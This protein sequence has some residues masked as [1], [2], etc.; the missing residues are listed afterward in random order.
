MDLLKTL[1][2]LFLLLNTAYTTGKLPEN[3]CNYY[4][5]THT[6]EKCMQTEKITRKICKKQTKPC[7]NKTRLKYNLITKT[8]KLNKAELATTI[9]QDIYQQK[10][11]Y[12]KPDQTKTIIKNAGI[13][14]IE[15]SPKTKTGTIYIETRHNIKLPKTHRKCGK[16][17]S[18]QK[19]KK[20]TT[21]KVN[22]KL[23]GRGKTIKYTVE[24]TKRLE[25]K[26]TLQINVKYQ[27]NTFKANKTVNKSEVECILNK[28]LEKKT[29]IT[30]TD[31]E[32]IKIRRFGSAKL[33]ETKYGALKL[34][35]RNSSKELKRN[36]KQRRKLK[37]GEAFKIPSYL[38]IFASIYYLLRKITS[39]T[40]SKSF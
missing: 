25:I 31:S 4:E 34:E 9:N 33:K 3:Q 36:Y 16:T 17:Y 20:K 23:E 19:L 38:V 30:L 32:T 2:I 10:N 28:S 35:K 22:N 6:R 15:T 5:N 21:T 1:P 40:G 29:S 24:T 39:K 11:T 18:L 37:Q 12:I 13:E 27:V 8:T 7:K 26:S 14:I